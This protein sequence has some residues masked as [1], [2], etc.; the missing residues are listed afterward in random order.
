[1]ELP[2]IGLQLETRKARVREIAQFFGV[3]DDHLDE[4]GWGKSWW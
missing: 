2:D 4:N 1:M 3:V